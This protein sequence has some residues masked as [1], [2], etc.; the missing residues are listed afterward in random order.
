[1]EVTFTYLY[2]RLLLHVVVDI[3]V[4]DHT[5]VHSGLLC[6]ALEMAE[7]HTVPRVV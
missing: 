6:P 3:R 5:V 7:N 2:K 1:V 4:Q